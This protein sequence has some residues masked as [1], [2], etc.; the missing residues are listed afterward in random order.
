MSKF[1][2]LLQSGED[3]V[4]SDEIQVTAYEQAYI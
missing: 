3:D 2:D 4:D 1:L